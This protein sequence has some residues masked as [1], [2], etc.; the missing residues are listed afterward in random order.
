MSAFATGNACTRHVLSNKLTSTPSVAGSLYESHLANRFDSPST[1]SKELTAVARLLEWG[2]ASAVDVERTLLQGHFLSALQIADFAQWL[3]RRS[4]HEGFKPIPHAFRVQYNATLDAVARAEAYFARQA[5]APSEPSIDPTTQF[6]GAI[7]F[8]RGAWSSQKAKVKKEPLAPDLTDKE[9]QKIE[10]FLR[11]D[12]H[13][14]GIKR[15]LAERDYL[16]WRMAIE[17]GMRIGEILCMRLEDCPSR[18][19]PYFSIVRIEERH[20]ASD[21][22]HPYAPRP[23]TLSRDLGFVLEATRFPRLATDFVM[24][25]RYVTQESKGR[26][27][28][29]FLLPHQF[30][31]VSK[32]GA[33]LSRQSATAIAHKISIGTGIAFH[34]HLARHAFFNRAYTAIRAQPEM[35]EQRARTQ[36]LLAWGGW[37]STASLDIYIRRARR[38]RTQNALRVWQE[39]G[40]TWSALN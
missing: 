26:T 27:V 20:D 19:R 10:A 21:P 18:G 6:K 4:G 35:D 3:K 24:N 40:D 29:R 32:G 36:D 28:R 30:L 2:L 8:Q 12:T 22:R 25:Y 23:K 17:C 33:P 31:I 39:G 11:P 5:F 37:E 38:E 34:W 1:C 16:V 13:L 9:I 7:E 15:Q 14:T